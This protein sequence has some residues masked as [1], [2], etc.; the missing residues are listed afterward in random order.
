[1]SD[2]LRM[3]GEEGKGEAIVFT[4]CEY[5]EFHTSRSVEVPHPSPDRQTDSCGQQVLCSTT[6]CLSC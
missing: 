6:S 3:R 4:K 1:M 5:F 2:S